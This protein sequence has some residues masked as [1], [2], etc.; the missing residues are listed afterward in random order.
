MEEGP[1]RL[2]AERARVP[3]EGGAAVAMAALAATLAVAVALQWGRARKEKDPP[4]LRL[5]QAGYRGLLRGL[6]HAHWVVV[7]LA[8][9]LC[10]A[11]G[12]IAFTFGGEF[13]PYF[14]EGHFIAP[15]FLLSAHKPA[16]SVG[17][18]LRNCTSPLS[19]VAASSRTAEMTSSWTPSPRSTL[20]FRM[21]AC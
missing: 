15:G 9:V 6:A 17:K 11:V 2:V 21:Q 16:L 10:V 7:G 18:T 19:K 1:V 8:L 4:L 20:R 5:T 3:V 14:R 13:L 12:R